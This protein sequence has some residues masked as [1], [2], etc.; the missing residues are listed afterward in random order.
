[1]NMIKIIILILIGL[2]SL[3]Q[4]AN[5]D[6]NMITGTWKTI[7]DETRKV[8]S[9]VELTIKDNKLYGTITKLFPNEGE[10]DNPL[11]DKC[12]NEKKDQPILGLQIID[13]LTL[14][15]NEWKDGQILDPNNGK[16]YDC[17]I[18]LENGKLQVRGYIGFFFRTQEWIRG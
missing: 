8:R 5:A 7:D 15:Q 9:L 10:A 3:S 12:S 18:W 16:T 11:C 4:P 2:L 17:K 14:K 13:G 6:K 1:M